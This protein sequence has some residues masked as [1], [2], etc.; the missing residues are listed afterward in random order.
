MDIPEKFSCEM[1]KSSRASKRLAAKR[2][3]QIPD[4]EPNNAAEAAQ[5]EQD[6]QH[7]PIESPGPEDAASDEE[8]QA[9]DYDQDRTGDNE[10]PEPE[11]D[12][13]PQQV[14]KNS[15]KRRQQE[16]R[17][18]ISKDL[19]RAQQLRREVPAKRGRTVNFVAHEPIDT[20]EDEET[21]WIQEKD[22]LPNLRDSARNWLPDGERG[23]QAKGNTKSD[24]RRRELETRV[25]TPSSAV[26]DQQ[27]RDDNHQALMEKCSRQGRDILRQ[28][29]FP[30][31]FSGKAGQDID[32]FF[33]RFERRA[34]Q[35]Y[36]TGADKIVCLLSCLQ[37]PAASAYSEWMTNGELL[38]L[39]FAQTKEKLIKRFPASR[40]T[41]HDAIRALMQMKQGK[42]E[43]V[44]D[45]EFRFRNVLRKAP[46]MQ[47]DTMPVLQAWISSVRS[48][49]AARIYDCVGSATKP[50][51]LDE[52][53]AKTS[54]I[55]AFIGAV[56]QDDI[57]DDDQQYKDSPP[58]KRRQTAWKQPQTVNAVRAKAQND[59]LEE[60]RQLYR[61]EPPAAEERQQ[62]K[63][64]G[65]NPNQS[66]RCFWR[67]PRS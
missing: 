2:G 25:A 54:E 4:E 5:V 48:E 41:E 13:E 61:Q 11:Q 20:S 18:L 3:E 60:M 17:L 15:K 38:D 52:L 58:S 12:S 10:T 30:E 65:R 33:E 34:V 35:A 29:P 59:D 42:K 47:P 24:S 36:W 49:F 21:I 7:D 66:T 63:D 8:I 46:S 27:R 44:A 32:E 62:L 1:K 19:G 22:Q 37:G 50:A 26:R 40:V 45:F 9:D 23:T 39:N 51:T 16:P 67:R 55:E 64:R 53:T 6:D 14:K 56:E 57:E 28:Q 43:S 31:P